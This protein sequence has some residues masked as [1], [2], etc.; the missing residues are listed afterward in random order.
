[1]RAR[2]SAFE[3]LLPAAFDAMAAP[4]AVEAPSSSVCQPLA[5]ELRPNVTLGWD[6]ELT[7]YAGDGILTQIPVPPTGLKTHNYGM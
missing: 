6:P 5:K 3:D 2:R 1:M 4:A 7:T